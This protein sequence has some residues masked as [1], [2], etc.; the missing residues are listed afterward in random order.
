MVE[1]AREHI[2]IQAP[3]E[4]CLEVLTD[5]ER[6][7]EWASNLTSAEVVERDDLGRALVV[8]YKAEAM[9]R[10]TT[11]RLRYDYAG[12]P[13]RLAWQLESGDIQRE[14]DGLY[15]L[16]P[17]DEPDTTEVGYELAVDLIMPI[18]GFVK[19]RAETMILT[20]ALDE[21]KARVEQLASPQA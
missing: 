17:A 4:R 16:R 11:Y 6:Y 1:Q 12:A 8:E 14:L 15:D 18:P 2:T 10:T 19:R 9:G 21:L 13:S 20:Y 5:F 3:V 7:P